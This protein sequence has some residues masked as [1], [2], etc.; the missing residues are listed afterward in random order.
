MLF[1]TLTT[2]SS[3]PVSVCSSSL[4]RLLRAAVDIWAC[5]I[6]LLG[7]ATKTPRIHSNSREDLE[8]LAEI[9]ELLGW[10][11]LDAAAAELGEFF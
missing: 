11:R 7:L 9:G 8:I 2:T 4:S 5:G 1:L 6:L 3:V 10:K